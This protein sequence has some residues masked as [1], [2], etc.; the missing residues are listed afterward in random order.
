M[1]RSPT[2]SF[3]V[4]RSLGADG[5]EIAVFISM[6][7]GEFGCMVVPATAMHGVSPKPNTGTMTRAH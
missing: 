6:L 5:D 3:A 4:D 1:E 7:R 2:I